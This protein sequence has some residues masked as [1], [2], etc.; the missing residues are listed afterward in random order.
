MPRL[1]VACLRLILQAVRICVTGSLM[2]TTLHGIG[3]LIRMPS[4]VFFAMLTHCSRACV[5]T[6]PT[7][8]GGQVCSHA[9]MPCDH[10][11]G[12]GVASRT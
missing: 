3:S 10:R 2:I 8:P 11:T 6:N 5:S 1:P 12:V 4:V 9:A 7:R